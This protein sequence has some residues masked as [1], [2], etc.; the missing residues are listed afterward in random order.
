MYV[1]VAISVV[2]I[3]IVIF[4]G[5]LGFVQEYKTEKTMESLK[6]MASPVSKVRRDGVVK[7]IETRLL[8]PG[9][10][11]LVEAGD[12]IGADAILLDS[13]DLRIDE[14]LLTGESVPVFKTASMKEAQPIFMGSVAVSGHGIARVMYTGAK[15]EMG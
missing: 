3:A 12:R 5:V 10:I 11:L 13:T 14:S 4:N 8:V 1:L 9:D 2:I 7:I 15:T 6:A